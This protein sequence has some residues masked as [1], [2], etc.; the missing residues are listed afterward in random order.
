[1]I[2]EIPRISINLS[3]GISYYLSV[4]EEG[5]DS[6]YHTI[7]GDRLSKSSP[8]LIY[9]SLFEENSRVRLIVFC[10]D[11]V[12]KKGVKAGLVAR[13]IAKALGGSGGG[14]ARFAQGGVGKRPEVLP[15]FQAILLNQIESRS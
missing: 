12:Q 1:M 6:E 8:S 10:G 3:S 15:D 13:E 7:V 11:D 2:N 5:L 14:D 4:F 9:L